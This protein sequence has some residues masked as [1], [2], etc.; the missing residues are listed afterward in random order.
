VAECAPTPHD[1]LRCQLWDMGGI[2]LRH[3]DDLAGR[4]D[5]LVGS[6]AIL[7]AELQSARRQHAALQYL[8]TTQQ[9]DDFD[10]HPDGT[11]KARAGKPSPADEVQELRAQLQGFAVATAQQI[12]E[13]RAL[14]GSNDATAPAPR[15]SQQGSTQRSSAGFGMD[16]PPSQRED[17]GLT[18]ESPPSERQADADAQSALVAGNAAVNI[19]RVERVRA[20][21]LAVEVAKL[22]QEREQLL[23]QLE[24]S[25]TAP[26]GDA[27]AN[28]KHCLPTH[29]LHHVQSTIVHDSQ[30]STDSRRVWM[31]SEHAVAC[32]R[33]EWRRCRR[34]RRAV[35]GAPR[36]PQVTEGQGVSALARAREPVTGAR[37]ATRVR[38]RHVGRQRGAVCRRRAAAVH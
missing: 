16:R 10:G 6:V 28:S 29:V 20:R 35:I 8:L 34:Q 26:A 30:V 7:A 1:G 37:P 12:R 24:V 21:K 2:V 33:C 25:S 13:L 14:D 9:H 32:R 15:P 19:A 23:E 18:V 27:G 36:R 11:Q 31:A 38:A 5:D 17:S 22:K 4:M 3:A